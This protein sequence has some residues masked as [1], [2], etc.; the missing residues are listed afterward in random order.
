MWGSRLFEEASTA[1]DRREHR[2][3][4]RRLERRKYR[5][6]LLEELFVEEINKIDPEF[7]IRLRESKF[8]FEDRS[9]KNTF[10]LFN[11]K[12]EGGYNDKVFFSK[13]PTIYHL[14][15][16]LINGNK[17]DVRA[18]FLAIHNILK[19]RGHFLLAGNDINISLSLN[20]TLT[21]LFE[22]L[23]IHLGI[24]VEF[25]NKLKDIEKIALDKNLSKSDKQKKIVQLLETD[26]KKQ[27]AD[28]FKLSL[29]LTANMEN[30]F[31]KENEQGLEFINAENKIKK[32]QFD[33]SYEENI[34]EFDQFYGEYFE[35]ID[36]C[37]KIYDAISL[38]QILVDGKGLS[39]SK[40]LSYEKH[41]EDLKL[42]KKVLKNI[43]K[44]YDNKG[45]DR[46]VYK[47]LKEDKDK[48]TNYV[49]YSKL[50]NNGTATTKEEFYKFLS[51]NLD[52]KKFG[53]LNKEDIETLDY[54]NSEILLGRFL[55]LQKEKINGV[56]PYQLQ[57]KEL[58]QIL[59]NAS[60]Y[61][62]FL[63]KIEDGMTVKDKIISLIKFRIPY[64]VGPLNE[65]N[66]IENGNGFAW[67][68]KKKNEKIFP[69][70]FN[71]VVDIEKSAEKFIN[72]LTNKCTYIKEET[73]LPKNSIIYSKFM[74]LNELNNL[75]YGNKKLDIE[76]K[77]KM[78]TDLFLEKKDNRKVTEKRILE[79]FR[80][81]GINDGK[82][83]LTGLNNEIHADMKSYR[84]MCEIMGENFNINVAE[85]IIN[86]IT[87]FHGEK[88][89]LI[90]K[91]KNVYGKMFNDE[92]I[93][94]LSKLNYS[95]WGRLSKK[96]LTDIKCYIDADGIN[97]PVSILEAMEV[98]N[99]NLMEL[100]SNKY[101]FI[102]CIDDINNKYFGDRDI[103][104]SELIDEL[105]VSPAVKRGIW[106]SVRI[107]EEIVSIIGHNPKKIF[108]E[109]TRHNEEKVQKSS[110]RH[111]L[112]ELYK[113]IRKDPEYVEL[114]KEFDSTTD[115]DSFKIKKL[116]LY[117]MQLGKC[118]Y[119]KEKIDFD[120][121]FTDSYDIDH[122]YPRSKTKDDSIHNN[123]VLVKAKYN[124]EKTDV[125]PIDINIQKNMNSFWN[126]LY[127]KKFITEEKYKRL[128]R[129]SDLTDEELAKFISRQLVE[130]SQSTKATA[131][132]L[133]QIYGDSDICYVK[134]ENV[135]DFR[136]GSSRQKDKND[137]Q[138]L[139]VKCREV[140][141][142]HHAKDAYL[143]IVVG[144][145]YDVKFTKNP[146]NF[147]KK[148]KMGNKSNYSLNHMFC[149]DVE[150]NGYKA[151]DSSETIKTVGR[152]MKSNDVRITKHVHPTRGELYDATIYKAKIAKTGSYMPLKS[153]KNTPLSDVTKYG[154]YT[155][156]KIAYYSVYKYKFSDK[157][158]IKTEIR[159]IP[160]PIYLSKND[161]DIKEYVKNYLNDRVNSKL[162][163]FTKIYDKLY[164]NSL[165][166]INGY[167]YY[168]GGKTNDRVWIDNA[169]SIV[170]DD[171]IE[172]L[173]KRIS[174]DIK[175]GYEI[176]VSDDEL[177]D[178]YESLAEKAN[179]KIFYNRL[180]DFEKIFSNMDVKKKFVKLEK[181]DKCRVLLQLLNVLTDSQ[182][183]YKLE[184]VGLKHSR[185]NI[186]MKISN[187]EEFKVINSSITGLYS[188]EIDILNI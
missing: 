37:K 112:E 11:D 53:K 144:N 38:S 121:L 110:R 89:I 117:F 145:V 46:L 15:S 104:A 16:A 77:M 40:V 155:K 183:T 13:Y 84:D 71:D 88:K 111:N 166:K 87:V 25:E 81:N 131:E 142:F 41:K 97:F 59:N 143:N 138:K 44:A 28:V 147:I 180:S 152:M 128:I 31:G 79:Y 90:N 107:L 73:V 85:N 5:L 139:F 2:S 135:S 83:K 24:E 18:V 113:A 50:S 101:E 61:L 126:F 58:T 163:D 68:E 4:R 82:E 43:D 102:S 91:I 106:Q 29:G 186:G 95:D 65:Y 123:L 156:I 39:E 115:T 19:N 172:Y 33:S 67:I 3:N 94:K 70:N 64:Y 177:M 56:I 35:I 134:A 185:S 175:Y 72:N 158:L 174:N 55:P 178:I 130:T 78:Y 184:M 22:Y 182:T 57:M 36:I 133:K 1:Q 49:N 96:L 168:L 154:G 51:K 151:W 109:M 47:V 136:Y 114:I 116:Y 157:N 173:I 93:S 14:R 125:Y 9:L 63:N 99:K 7:F 179:K 118:A 42:L 8:H 80:I 124:R 103:S 23:K 160:I 76:L 122:I 26:Y 30:I 159:L 187:L 92:Q 146:V 86:W 27:L 108:I 150:R 12:M 161:D 60:K 129:T 54:I 165:I 74:V 17:E 105:Y 34:A 162:I 137:I 167:L 32:I 149:F 20:D 188:N 10:I 21:D 45:E 169:V 171:K 132:V 140:N 153:S 62:P 141:H 48:G 52:L 98:S 120:K 69:W 181:N 100:L 75:Q 127:T 148:N 66:R 6:D 119:S 164:V 176:N 170:L